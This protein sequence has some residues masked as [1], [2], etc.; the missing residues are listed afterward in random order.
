MST[1]TA[2]LK[3]LVEVL[4]DGKKFYE[5]AGKKVDL[6]ELKQLFGRMAK[7]KASIAADLK[8]SI[9]SSGEKAPAGGT[10]GGA[11]RKG[12]GEI[13]ASLSHSPNTAYVDQL[14]A[15][16]DRIVSAFRDA[17]K[18]SDSPVVRELA[19]TYMSNVLRDHNEMS[20]LKHRLDAAT[21]H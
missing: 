9:V 7:D 1:G 15:F 10:L 12:L 6:P 20:A 13:R 17:A 4:N 8:A 21:K 14:E 19:T 18:E 5:E 3:E 16:E 2:T 11:L